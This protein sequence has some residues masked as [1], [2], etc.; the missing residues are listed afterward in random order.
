MLTFTYKRILFRFC[1]YC[2]CFYFSLSLI[3]FNCFEDVCFFVCVR[4]RMFLNVYR[5]HHSGRRVEL[6]ICESFGWVFSWSDG[7]KKSMDETLIITVKRIRKKKRKSKR[8]NESSL[9]RFH[10]DI[11]P[12]QNIDQY[13]TLQYVICI[14][15]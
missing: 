5:C 13:A 14:D 2:G 10:I 15:F 6:V 4:K 7:E 1:Y 11:L 12:C 8:I 3:L 9:Y